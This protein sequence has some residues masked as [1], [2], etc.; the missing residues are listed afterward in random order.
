[1]AADTFIVKLIWRLS[2]NL[3]YHDFFIKISDNIPLGGGGGGALECNLAGRC[4]FLRISTTCLGKA[5]AFRYP[6]SELLDHKSFEK[7]QGNNNL[8]FLKTIVY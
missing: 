5:F 3:L 2:G 6:V 4:P 8:L 7:Q 1:M